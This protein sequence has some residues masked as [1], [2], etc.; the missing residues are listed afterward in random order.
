MKE[1]IPKW[2]TFVLTT[3][4]FT[5]IAFNFCLYPILGCS[6]YGQERDQV[7]EQIF[8]E[9]RENLEKARAENLALLSPNNFARANEFNQKALA[10]YEKG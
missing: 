10:D 5:L 6:C 2:S 8:K 4:I 1:Q 7:K 3:M 9:V